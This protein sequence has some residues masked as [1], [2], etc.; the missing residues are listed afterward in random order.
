MECGMQTKRRSSASSYERAWTQKNALGITWSLNDLSTLFP[1]QKGFVFQNSQARTPRNW[2]CIW[3]LSSFVLSSLYN[4]FPWCYHPRFWIVNR[5]LFFN[6]LQKWTNIDAIS[7]FFSLWLFTW[8]RPKNDSTKMKKNPGRRTG[9]KV[10]LCAW[11]EDEAPSEV[12]NTTG[13]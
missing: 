7:H 4:Y 3:L 5:F 13:C 1:E 6:L 12:W 2:W 8:R 9:K 11:K 10:K